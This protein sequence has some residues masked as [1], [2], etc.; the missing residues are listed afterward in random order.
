ME[1]IVEDGS[2][3]ADANSYC[4]LADADAY[5][6][7][8]V[9]GLDWFTD[10]NGAGPIEA[11]IREARLIQATRL[12]DEQIAWR[13]Q[14]ASFTQALAFP[15]MWYTDK[16][17]RQIA[18]NVVPTEVKSAAAELARLILTEDRAA[19]AEDF[20]ETAVSMGGTSITYG[21]RGGARRRII[22]ASV[23]SLVSHLTDT[24]RVVRA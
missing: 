22:P 7:A 16:F 1:L 18:F 2:G 23:R 14:P 20:Q 24:S 12:L 11:S 21:N 3:R 8:H 4:S 10:A 9:S 17:G 19:L 13:G 5:H 15:G 6:E